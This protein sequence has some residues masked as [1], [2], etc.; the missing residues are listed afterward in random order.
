M[1]QLVPFFE[2]RGWEVRFDPFLDAEVFE[3]FYTP[4]KRLNKA[5]QV[6]SRSLARLRL[7]TTA[8]GV[9][10]V[11]VQREASLVGPAFTDE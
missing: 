1:T 11:F 7:A 10:A 2:A 8:M 5:S 9:D 6:A 3:H 4:G